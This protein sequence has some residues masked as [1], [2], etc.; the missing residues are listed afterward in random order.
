[1]AVD[2]NVIFALL[3]QGKTY[4]VDAT[5]NYIGFNEYAER[6]QGRQ[7]LIEDGD[8]Y[9]YT[10]VP[11]TTYQQNLDAEKAVLTIKGSDLE[12]TVSHDWKGEKKENILY[13]LNSIKKE[14]SDEIFVRFLSDNN[15]D[16]H[17]AHLVATNLTDYDKTLNVKYDLKHS[18]AITTFGKE[19]Y[20]DIDNKK[21]FADF[22]FDLKERETD[23]WFSYK[24]NM[25]REVELTIPDG[26]TVTAMPPDVAVK[27]DDYEF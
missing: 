8:K 24:T 5:E 6:I 14:K 1:M 18:N 3:Y 21:E 15:K 13:N 26:Y 22:T 27:N 25:Q 2:N 12:G 10:K 19:L 16:Y 17:I 4:F 7:V 20:E 23:Y 11:T 9:I